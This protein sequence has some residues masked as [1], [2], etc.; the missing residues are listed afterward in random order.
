VELIDLARFLTRHRVLVAVGCVLSIVAGLLAASRTE[1]SAVRSGMA[2]GRVLIDQDPSLL[3]DLKGKGEQTIGIRARLFGDLLS[4]DEG[5]AA[6]A[7]ATGVDP[8]LISV[9]T[10]AAGPAT[11]QV[12]LPQKASEYAAATRNAKP[13]G[14]TVI[15]DD[16]VPMLTF[17][18][19]APTPRKAAQLVEGSIAG[20]DELIAARTIDPGDAVVATPVGP[21]RARLAPVP[22][23]VSPRIV[24]PAVALMVVLLWCGGLVV[25]S[26]LARALRGRERPAPQTEV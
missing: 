7:R 10:P 21:P 11:I 22:E 9:T 26:G 5:T 25:V 1:P 6:I 8:K 20:L 15:S 2:T 3:A 17:A 4:S 13:Y 18:T 12:P 24:A 16:R 19:H 23:H 14:V